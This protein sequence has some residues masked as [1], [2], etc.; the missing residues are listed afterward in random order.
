MKKKIN[1]IISPLESKLNIPSSHEFVL[2]GEWCEIFNTKNHL[3]TSTL[4]AIYVGG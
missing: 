1:L 2:L 3:A 4:L